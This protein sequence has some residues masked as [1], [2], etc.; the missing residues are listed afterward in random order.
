MLKLDVLF[1]RC[2]SVLSVNT[3]IQ[4]LIQISFLHKS[5]PNIL[6]LH[7]PDSLLY[8]LQQQSWLSADFDKMWGGSSTVPHL[9][10]VKITQ[11]PEHNRIRKS[12]QNLHLHYLHHGC[13]AERKQPSELLRLP[14][15]EPASQLQSET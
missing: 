13:S 14:V 3:D 11:I 4:N 5:F 6:I 2:T 15:Y 9:L 8:I 12:P 10:I 1:H 7:I